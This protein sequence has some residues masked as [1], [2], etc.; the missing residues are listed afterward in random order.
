MT[1]ELPTVGRYGETIEIFRLVVSDYRA[2][3]G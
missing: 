1:P 2:E 3:S